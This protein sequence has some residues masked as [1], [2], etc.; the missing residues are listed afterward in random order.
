MT[1]DYLTALDEIVRLAPTETYS[2]LAERYLALIASQPERV[3]GY[4]S[5]ALYAG[6]CSQ[7]PAANCVIDE[8][9]RLPTGRARSHYIKARIADEA[10]DPELSVDHYARALEL[11]PDNPRWRFN[12][13]L[14]QM[15]L[16]DFDQGSANYRCRFSAEDLEALGSV[17][18]WLPGQAGQRV[19]IWA[20]Q[21]LGD[22]LMFARLLPCLQG[23]P[24]R[25]TLQCDRRLMSILSLN[26]PALTFLPRGP[27]AALLH[28]F[29]AQIALGD[30]LSLFHRERGQPQVRDRFLRPVPRADVAQAVQAVRQPGRSLVGL[31]WL[32]MNASCGA[33]RSVPLGALLDV[34]SPDRHVLVNLQYLAPTVDLQAMRDRGFE[35][36]DGVDTHNDIEGL[37]ALAAHCDAI[38][39]IDNSTLHLAGSLGLRTLA[40]IPALANWRW[41]LKGSR[42]AWYPSVEL[43][44][45]TTPGDWKAE[46]QALRTQ[47]DAALHIGSVRDA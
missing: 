20:E 16:G 25:F 10:L 37:A 9:L 15:T 31:S 34:F 18:D 24:G 22:E 5:L 2:V 12:L 40:L 21:G 33:Q 23:H 8:A 42:S 26:H 30:L 43:L 6:L 47:I 44:R 19:L 39:S 27:V 14:A 13:G 45:Q 32:S 36:L 35:L 3:E 7:W 1:A 46:L 17:P 11:E 29:D 28:D 41:Q 4:Q 38:V